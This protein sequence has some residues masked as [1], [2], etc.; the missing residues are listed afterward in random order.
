[1][2][3]VP[4]ECAVTTPVDD[5]VA[6]SGLDDDHVMV[7]EVLPPPIVGF[8]EVVPEQLVMFTLELLK[9]NVLCIQSSIQN[10]NS[11]RCEVVDPVEVDTLLPSRVTN[12]EEL[13]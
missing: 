8:C 4:V 12:E 3:A 6:T 2:T 1:M 5:T 7:P 9:V 10:F 11:G 13:E